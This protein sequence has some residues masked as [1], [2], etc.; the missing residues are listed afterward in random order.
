MT[1]YSCQTDVGVSPR[2]GTDHD[3]AQFVAFGPDVIHEHLVGSELVL[4]GQ[5]VVL[6]LLHLFQFD[7][8]TQVPHHLNPA[9]GLADS[10]RERNEKMA[11]LLF[12]FSLLIQ[13]MAIVRFVFASETVR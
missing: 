1:I 10:M 8:F 12:R 9:S 2:F 4:D 7:T 11:N 3:F 6:T 13:T 5:R